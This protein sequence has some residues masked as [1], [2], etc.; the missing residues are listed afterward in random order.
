MLQ[1]I[2]KNKTKQPP[3]K[4]LWEKTQVCVTLSVTR[5]VSC[6]SLHVHAC[7][8]AWTPTHL[9]LS[10]IHTHTH[11]HT[12]IH[13]QHIHTYM[14]TYTPHIHA[15]FY[16]A[17]HIYTLSCTHTHNSET[18]IHMHANLQP[19]TH[20]TQKLTPTPGNTNCCWSCILHLSHACF[21]SVMPGTQ[22]R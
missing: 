13:T 1:Y 19:H 3:E 17:H 9:S 14:Q 2:R 4:W 8:N 16:A 18:H 12:L 5:H 6:S 10:H 22:S 21:S 7:S 20:I 15:H 11:T